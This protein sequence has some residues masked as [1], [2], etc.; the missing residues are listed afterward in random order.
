LIEFP[1]KISPCSSVPEPPL[2][3]AHE[4]AVRDDP[5]LLF[6]S[7]ADIAASMN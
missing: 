2:G 7:I 6:R 4:A 1:E 3:F 5:F